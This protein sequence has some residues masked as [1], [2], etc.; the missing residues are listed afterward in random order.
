LRIDSAHRNHDAPSLISVDD[1]KFDAVG[2]CLPNF[3]KEAPMPATVVPPSSVCSTLAAR[4]DARRP[5]GTSAAAAPAGPRSPGPPRSGGAPHNRRFSNRR[6][7]GATGPSTRGPASPDEHEILFQKFFK[8]VGPRTYAAQ[9]KRAKNGNHYL[10]LME[11]KR[12]ESNGEIRK[13]RLFI[14]SEDFVEFFRLIKSAAEFI[15]EHPLPAD[16]RE[17]RKHFWAKQSGGG[18]RATAATGS[19][20]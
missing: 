19:H 18:D 10:V 16:V 2:S 15:K 12:D 13:T 14:Y 17:K 9:V 11:G 20:A 8:S 1:V 6:A 5:P 4:P 3:G 7:G